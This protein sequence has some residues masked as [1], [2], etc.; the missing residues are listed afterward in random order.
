[1]RGSRLTILL[2]GALLGAA[3]LVSLSILLRG[4]GEHQS[5]RVTNALDRATLLAPR[6][7]DWA[8]TRGATPGETLVAPWIEPFEELVVEDPLKLDLSPED[9]RR[10]ENGDLVVVSRLGDKVLSVVGFIRSD[11]GPIAV[12]LVETSSDTSRVAS[13]RT[14]IG[15][16]ALILLCAVVG[17]VLA[18]LGGETPVADSPAP[19]LRAYEE[20]M[21]RLRLRED[22]RLAAFDRE[23]LRL[24]SILRDREAMARAGELTAGI[25]HEVRNSMGAIATHAKLAEKAEEERVR[26]AAR[27]IG[28]EVRTLQSVMNRFLDFI[29][30]EKVQA[31]EFDLARMVNRVAARERANHDAQIEIA[32][33]S[34]MVG[35][36]EDLLERAVENVVRNAVQASGPGA[37]VS[38]KFGADPTHAFVVVEDRGPGIADVEKALRPFE[39]DRAGGLGLG[40]PL[41][42]KI[43][44]LHQGALELGPRAGS[45]GT[46]AVCRWPKSGPDATSGNAERVD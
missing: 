23:K 7:A 41:V 20:A 12:R 46:T 31:G 16:H 33:T 9:R 32:G 4:L 29:R 27:A 42:L 30:T 3:E 25:V 36:D 28:D 39:S 43:L 13:D 19:A 11:Q 10:A 15:Q 14:L 2:A 6:I 22:E 44:T 34:T 40:L 8:R 37:L 26:S 38:I 5:Q 17:L 21:S 45:S 35:G 18:A 24:T 1:M